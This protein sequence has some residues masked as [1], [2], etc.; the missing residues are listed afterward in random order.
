[1]SQ[2]PLQM[3]KPGSERETLA[4]GPRASEKDQ[5]LGHPFHA[6]VLLLEI[7][8]WLW[9]G[10][11]FRDSPPGPSQLLQHTPT[12]LPPRYHILVSFL[13]LHFLPLSLAVPYL[14]YWGGI[15]LMYYMAGAEPENP[16]T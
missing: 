5:N 7:I 9:K 13:E 14:K 2:P 3:N 16:E 15:T 4:Q 11:G 6:M 1:M 10:R 12:P 8:S